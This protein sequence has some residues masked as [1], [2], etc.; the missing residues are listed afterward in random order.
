MTEITPAW[1][2]SEIKQNAHPGN[3]FYTTVLSTVD[4]GDPA[5]RMVVLRE[6]NPDK[7]LIS[8]YSDNRSAKIKQLL[9]N[10]NIQMLFYHRE[11]QYQLILSGTALISDNTERLHRTWEI[12][13]RKDAYRTEDAPGTAVSAPLGHLIHTDDPMAGFSNFA[14]VDCIIDK[15]EL[16][17]IN[18]NEG[19]RR[20]RFSFYEGDWDH[21]WL[22]P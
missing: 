7:R 20:L 5:S 2:W 22:V 13:K 9:E 4:N 16:Y 15:M 17:Q 10:P 14:I 12:L 11:Q 6:I 3:D 8:F 21:S 1:I 19:N 18:N